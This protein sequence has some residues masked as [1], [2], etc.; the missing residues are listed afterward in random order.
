[1][2]DK[3]PII[4]AGRGRVRMLDGMCGWEEVC[5]VGRR[6]R[7]WDGAEAWYDKP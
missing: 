5:F 6:I 3:G 7:Y 4:R 1:M 2:D